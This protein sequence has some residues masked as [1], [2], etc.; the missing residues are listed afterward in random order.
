[1]V[2][3]CVCLSCDGAAVESGLVLMC[4]A[5]VVGAVRLCLCDCATRRRCSGENVRWCRG[6]GW[7]GGG[8]RG[9]P[10]VTARVPEAYDD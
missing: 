6:G 7:R 3:V 10:R 5:C 1:M 2:A 4:C 9:P 8:S